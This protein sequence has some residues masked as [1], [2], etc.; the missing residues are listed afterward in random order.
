MHLLFDQLA[1]GVWTP[2]FLI[3]KTEEVSRAVIRAIEKKRFEAIIPFWL[4]V[5]CRVK[6]LFPA[7]FRFLS[8]HTLRLRQGQSFRK[9]G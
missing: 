2:E 9:D 6:A 7:L 5:V 8:Y 3:L 1:A 4:A